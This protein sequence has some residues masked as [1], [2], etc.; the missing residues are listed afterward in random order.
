MNTH[1][2]FAQL[3]KRVN[4]PDCEFVKSR[5]FPGTAKEGLRIPRPHQNG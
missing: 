2:L 5:Y 1:A 3:W 4:C